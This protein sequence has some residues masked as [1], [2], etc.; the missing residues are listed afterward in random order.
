MI[1][2]KIVDAN[3]FCVFLPDGL[4][5]AWIE[6]IP[7]KF[8][9]P[10][11]LQLQVPTASEFSFT[12]FMGSIKG[13]VSCKLSN[14]AG[15]KVQVS[16]QQ[17]GHII[18]EIILSKD[19]KEFKFDNLASGIFV[20]RIIGEKFCWKDEVIEN[21]HLKSANVENIVFTQTGIPLEIESTHDTK[22]EIVGKNKAMMQQL[23]LKRNV[24]K[25]ICLSD[26]DSPPDSYTI[27]PDPS[28]CHEFEKN[29][30]PFVLG[31]K[32]QMVA[33]RHKY[34]WKIVSSGKITDLKLT[35]NGQSFTLDDLQKTDTGIKVTETKEGNGITYDISFFEIPK[36][37]VDWQIFSYGYIFE[38]NDFTI[39]TTSDCKFGITRVV[40]KKSHVIKGKLTPPIGE[41][42]I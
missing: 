24:A 29:V 27:K 25:K 8:F 4:Y 16:N 10:E 2:Q 15:V 30:Y 37:I 14:C 21:I 28:G 41:L 12:E 40:A 5:N 38:P 6:S 13:S 36:T 7:E 11:K 23:D 31:K 3:N 19:Q 39:D 35:K 32:V 22:V 34:S 42:L 20:I 17:S 1:R 26:P 9:I 18:Q 33:K